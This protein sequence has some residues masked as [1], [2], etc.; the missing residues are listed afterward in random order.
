MDTAPFPP[1]DKERVSDWRDTSE[2]RDLINY[3]ENEIS[4]KKKFAE[5]REIAIQVYNFRLDKDFSN[6]LTSC[7]EQIAVENKEQHPSDYKIKHY[8]ANCHLLP[9]S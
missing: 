9:V 4:Q 3:S 6:G 8:L 7:E 5:I 1:K 2:D